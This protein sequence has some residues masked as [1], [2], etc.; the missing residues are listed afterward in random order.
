MET[1]RN[2]ETRTTALSIRDVK[3]SYGTGDTAVN[4]LRGVSFDVLPG[5]LVALLGP[6]GSGKTTLLWLA[7]GVEPL[8]QGSISAGGVQMEGLTDA[9]V[10]EYRRNQVGLIFQN[11]NLLPTL[12]AIENVAI[13]LELSG[14]GKKEAA[15]QAIGALNRVG[16]QQEYDR[17]PDQL[18]GGQ[19]QRVAVARAIT[20]NRRLIL[21][22][23]PT[24]ALDSENAAAVMATL[25]ALVK[26]GS[27]ALVVTHDQDV[28][29][30][31]NRTLRLRDG[32]LQASR[33]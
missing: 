3:H 10:H 28:A 25:V 15:N 9:Q 24:G 22:D 14:V 18:S 23:E 26:A 1:L 33:S 7:A 21:A 11:F 31:C 5:E 12:T 19:Q 8:Q 16:L 6:S 30:Q 29:D 27:S 20:G 32:Q 13:V 17:F 4:V 2:Q